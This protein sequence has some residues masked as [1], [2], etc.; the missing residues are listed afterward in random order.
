MYNAFIIYKRRGTVFKNI[1]PKDAS[2]FYVMKII[3]CAEH[4]IVAMMFMLN[5]YIEVD[6]KWVNEKIKEE[7]YAESLQRG[8]K[9][10]KLN[11]V[12]K[13]CDIDILKNQEEKDLEC[14]FKKGMKVQKLVL[15]NGYDDIGLIN[16][17]E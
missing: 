14:V 15:P 2:D 10:E 1:L 6:P 17:T 9:E 13:K 4:A 5:Y 11:S 3:V 16:V 12:L 8:F 7:E